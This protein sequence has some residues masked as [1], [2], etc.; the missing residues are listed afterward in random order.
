MRVHC[1]LSL[2]CYLAGASTLLL[3]CGSDGSGT[4]SPGGAAGTS[5]S[6]G[7][8]QVRFLYKADWKDHL[9][10]CPGIADYRIK[11]GG[12]PVPITVPIDTT[13]DALGE[14]VGLEGRT[15]KDNDVLHI[16]TCVKSQTSKQTQQ[17]YGR[18]GT[19][20]SFSA[21]QRFTVTLG[22]SVASVAQ[23]P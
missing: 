6:V 11:F 13:P 4:E 21:A 20:L 2:V 18:F 14:Y 19:D 7:S 1:C 5:N 12:I 10:A 8:A 3:G 15:Y 17:A 22:G 23:D 16:F 9:G